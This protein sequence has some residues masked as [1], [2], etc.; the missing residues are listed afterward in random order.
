M[1]RRAWVSLGRSKEAASALPVADG[2]TAGMSIV[3]SESGGKGWA[4]AKWRQAA[5]PKAAT[6]IST[7]TTRRRLHDIGILPLLGTRSSAGRGG[8]TDRLTTVAAAASAN[9]PTDADD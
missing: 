3:T 1:L 5:D 8:Y 6:T 2:G 7:T 9:L 4:K